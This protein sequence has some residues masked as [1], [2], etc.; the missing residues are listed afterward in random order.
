MVRRIWVIQKI[1]YLSQ[2]YTGG[3]SMIDLLQAAVEPL[4][5]QYNL[6]VQSTI[7]M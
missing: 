2:V 4:T 5:R 6:E 7:I 3:S 1:R